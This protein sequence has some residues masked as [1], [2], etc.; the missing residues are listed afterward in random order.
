MQQATQHRVGQPLIYNSAC[1]YHRL[2]I[3]K[4][5]QA[6]GCKDT[7]PLSL[8]IT[9]TGDGHHSSSGAAVTET[10]Y[11]LT[12]DHPLSE[13]AAESR[14]AWGNDL[15]ILLCG[16]IGEGTELCMTLDHHVL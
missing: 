11:W 5:L 2:R 6:P 15:L 4:D 3:N 16:E 7:T 1:A 13:P 14:A 9:Q 8:R 12:G 10:S